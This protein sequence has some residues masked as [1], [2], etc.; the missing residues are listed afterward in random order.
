MRS[1]FSSAVLGLLLAAVPLRAAAMASAPEL[2]LGTAVGETE[3]PGALM[4]L[5]D[6]RS[7][8]CLCHARVR[9]ARR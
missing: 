1:W 8:T 5:G 2:V 6:G 3:D 4:A 9:S 7:T